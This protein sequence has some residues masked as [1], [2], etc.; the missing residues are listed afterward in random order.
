MV[1]YSLAITV[2]FASLLSAGL[3]RSTY[4]PYRTHYKMMH[5]GSNRE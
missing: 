3:F 1:G 5:A 4:R 2:G